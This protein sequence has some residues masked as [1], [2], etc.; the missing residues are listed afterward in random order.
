MHMKDGELIL[1]SYGFHDNYFTWIH[2]SA[3]AKSPYYFQTPIVT[4]KYEYISVIKNTVY[5]K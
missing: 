5:S 1:C 4:P 2:M 3:T